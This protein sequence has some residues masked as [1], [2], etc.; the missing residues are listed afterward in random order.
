[1][2][3]QVEMTDRGEP[4][5]SDSYALTVWNDNGGLAYS[6]NWNGTRSAEQVLAGG[7]LQV[8]GSAAKVSAPGMEADQMLDQEMSPLNRK[9][10]LQ[11]KVL[12]NPSP[13]RFTLNLSGG[14]NEPIQ[15]RVTDVLG[16]VVEA[17]KLPAGAQTL[18]VG[19]SW[20]NGNYILE[21]IQGAERKTVQLVKLR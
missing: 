14:S 8:R 5:S 3:L 1:M 9:P 16:R 20:I 17:R 18:Q 11:V 13:N 4:G 19:D 21:V 12:P 10:V 7:N 6:S 2:T 15:L